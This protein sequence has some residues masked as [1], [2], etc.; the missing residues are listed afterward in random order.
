MPCLILVYWCKF[1]P[2]I[3]RLDHTIYK[4]TLETIGMDVQCLL[5]EVNFTPHYRQPKDCQIGNIRDSLRER[6]TAQRSEIGAVLDEMLPR[7]LPDDKYICEHCY[8]LI[9]RA[10]NDPSRTEE[11]KQALEV[12]LEQIK[13]RAALKKRAGAYNH[14]IGGVILFKNKHMAI[15]KNGE[16]GSFIVAFDDL[17]QEGY[18][19]VCQQQ[20]PYTTSDGVSYDYYYYFQKIEY[21]GF[22]PILNMYVKPTN[23]ISTKTTRVNNNTS[24]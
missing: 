5:C 23:M 8:S 6:Y 18:R 14:D 11:C 1:F 7:S 4:N 20:Y 19:C 17:T 22:E 10:V 15:L 13:I 9:Y 2:Y 24:Q 21:I 16:W 12:R 3:G